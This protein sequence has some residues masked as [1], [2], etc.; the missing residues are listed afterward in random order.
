MQAYFNSPLMDVY[1]V[2]VQQQVVERL[3]F[4]TFS[5]APLSHLQMRAG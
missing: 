3:N 1:S 2:L 5:Q 4:Q